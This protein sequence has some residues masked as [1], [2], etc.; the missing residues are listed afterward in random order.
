MREERG[1]ALEGI[2]KRNR[3]EPAGLPRASAAIAGDAAAGA[4]PEVHATQKSSNA[5]FF[6][7]GAHEH[8]NQPP[9]EKV[10]RKSVLHFI[11]IL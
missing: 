7:C 3:G 6:Y 8:G 5:R 9:E 4:T 10:R 11:Y 1:E 2:A